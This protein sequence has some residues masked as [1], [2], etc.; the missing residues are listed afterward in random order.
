MPGQSTVNNKQLKVTYS[1]GFVKLVI[2]FFSNGILLFL[3]SQV[4]RISK[5]FMKRLIKT[6][7]Y[8]WLVVMIMLSCQD[9]MAQHERGM[10]PIQNY[11][12]KDYEAQPQNWVVKQNINGIIYI[13]NNIGL[14]EFKGANNQNEKWK[15]YKVSNGSTVRSLD[16]DD[17]GYV[18]VG[19]INEFGYFAPDSLR[20]GQLVY[21]SLTGQF[22]S[23]QSESTEIWHTVVN[24][25]E[26]YFASNTEIFY[27]HD[28][29]TKVLNIPSIKRV[30]KINDRVYLASAKTGLAE[31][32]HGEVVE[33]ENSKCFQRKTDNGK[34]VCDIK[35]VARYDDNSFLVVSKIFDTPLVQVSI[36]SKTISVKPFP[37][38]VDKVLK[39]SLIND[40]SFINDNVVL[41]TSNK[42]L[43]ILDRQGALVNIINR[44]SG[45]QNNRVNHVF[46]DD[47]NFVW[48][49]LNDGVSRIK[50]YSRYMKFPQVE[51]GF[52]GIIEGITRFNGHIYV[53]GA[54]GLFRLD[55]NTS[56][57]SDIDI[58]NKDI[59]DLSLSGFSRITDP[60]L[61]PAGSPVWAL[62]TIKNNGRE[63]MLLSTDTDVLEL[64]KYGRMR[65]IISVGPWC[66]HIDRNDPA[67]VYLGLYKGGVGSIYQQG[68]KWINEGRIGDLNIDV[69]NITHDEEGNLWFGTRDGVGRISKPVFID[70]EILNP[71]IR[72]FNDKNGLP[73]DDATVCSYF[74]QRMIFGTGDGLFEYH[75]QED[76]FLMVQDMG[77]WLKSRLVFRT[78]VDR[79]GNLWSVIFSENGKYIYLTRTFTDE[80]GKYNTERLIV[81]EGET[82]RFIY[83]DS[84]GILW[85]AGD[86]GVFKLKSVDKRYEDLPFRTYLNYVI[87]HQDTIFYGIFYNEKGFVIN[88][89]NEVLKPIV[90]YKDNNF[91]FVISSIG[92]NNEV[93]LMYSFYLEGDDEDWSSWGFN[94]S[95]RY[96]NL[97]EGKYTLHVKARDIFGNISEITT[98]SFTVKPPWYRTIWAYILYFILFVLVLVGS[99]KVSTRHLQRIIRERTAEIRK[100]KDLIEEKNNDIMD[101]IKY[102]R[103]IQETILPP[104]NSVAALFPNSF[105]LYEPRDIVSGDFYWLMDREE[106][107]VIAAADCTGHGVPGAFMSI[108]GITFLNEIAAKKEVKT[109]AEVL[110]QLR[111]NVIHSLTQRG[112]EGAQKDGM[113]IA[114]LAFSKDMSSVQYAGAYNPLF[115]IRQGELIEYK[116]NRFPVGKHQRD[117]QP[118]DNNEIELQK[119]DMLYVFSDGYIDQFGGPK[120]KKYMSKRFKR[121]L[122]EIHKQPVAEQKQ[123]LYQEIL[124]WRGSIEQ[125]DDI[126]V[127]GIRV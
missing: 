96:S 16:I 43:I 82:I 8:T 89:Q 10:L 99:I 60:D 110:N 37:T 113:D 9:S 57:F 119:D 27:Y 32:K 34:D 71:E 5:T 126:I 116:A 13:G 19:A 1:Y 4:N 124:Q 76:T 25:R 86:N 41:A 38:S 52:E 46:Y 80:K 94:N 73:K 109:A 39:S 28:G 67:R 101:S 21:Y 24:G 108:M 102:A 117:D 18:F 115:I 118:F 44:E 64:D 66:F 75:A 83:P 78:K 81:D 2:I 48:A 95:R 77:E 90:R 14:L 59:S 22:D 104:D 122:I 30:F 103:R 55:E 98:Y 84:N 40:M 72:L 123:L 58:N 93:P 53:C 20:K 56:D 12:P 106:V 107:S 112:E 97:H 6:V 42:G 61:L 127:I 36:E 15:L 17:R 111:C 23:L 31:L 3:H 85:A 92:Y 79:D 91:Q 100:Q 68:D 45:L 65:E 63:V 74:Q 35:S 49:A 47:Q 88:Q 54:K 70:H 11:T 26:V 114:L 51:S 7:L 50:L 33:L 125:V 29:E 62:K 105:I 121:L 87:S 120:G 69:Y